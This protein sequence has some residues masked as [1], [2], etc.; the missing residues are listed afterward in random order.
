MHPE[1]AG[2]PFNALIKSSLIQS[3][4]RGSNNARGGKLRR[5]FAFDSR[6]PDEWL[7]SSESGRGIDQGPSRGNGPPSGEKRR[8]LVPASGFFP[9]HGAVTRRKRTRL[10]F[11]AEA[12]LGQIRPDENQRTKAKG[13]ACRPRGKIRRIQTLSRSTS[14]R[15]FE[16]RDGSRASL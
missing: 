6:C 14:A 7:V 3:D 5:L 13:V 15:C 9:G 1:I 2:T 11:Q 12:T 8:S 4:H 16:K 10:I